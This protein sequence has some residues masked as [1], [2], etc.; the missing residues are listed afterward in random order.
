MGCWNNFT[1]L[2]TFPA[3]VRGIPESDKMYNPSSMFVVS[4]SVGTRVEKPQRGGGR[5]LKPPQDVRWLQ[6]QQQSG[7]YSCW[8]ANGTATFMK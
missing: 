1:I 7:R 3:P 8:S 5:V 6:P 4:N 2:Q